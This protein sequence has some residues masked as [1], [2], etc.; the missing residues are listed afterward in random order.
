METGDSSRARTRERR[1]NEQLKRQL[2]P[3]WRQERIDVEL[4]INGTALEVLIVEGHSH[5]ETTPIEERSDGLRVFVA[6]TAFLARKKF[7]L[8]PI[9]LVD[10]LETHLHL[11]AQADLVEVLT[12]D[13]EASQVLYTTH[14]PGCLPRDLGT[15]IRLVTPDETNRSVSMLRNDFWTSGAGFS[16]LL[17]AMGASAA[18]FSAL[19]KA[20]F[21]EGPSDMIL[22]PSLFR[23]ALGLE[24]IEFQV[25]HGLAQIN[26]SVDDLELAAAKVVYLLDGDEGGTEYRERLVDLVAGPR[27]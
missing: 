1:A 15:G 26:G 2:G 11:D 20:V 9:L 16:P 5:G 23:I 14:S 27:F 13:V 21:C 18:A 6:L 8:P 7:E 24:D 19:R 10:E 3:R 17:F 4:R 25:A 22:L 12:K